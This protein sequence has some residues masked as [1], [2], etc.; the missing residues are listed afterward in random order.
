M[1]VVGLVVGLETHIADLV[2]PLETLLLDAVLGQD[3]PQA[4]RPLAATALS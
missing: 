3:E 1:M 4:Q 2:D